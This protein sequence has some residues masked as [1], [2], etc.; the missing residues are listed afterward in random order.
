MVFTNDDPNL[1]QEG[2]RQAARSACEKAVMNYWRAMDGTISD[3]KV[4]DAVGNALFGTTEDVHSQLRDRFDPQDRLMLW[5]DFNLNDSKTIQGS[6]RKF[7][8]VGA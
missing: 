3:Q 8:E 1:T 4:Q 5:F 6:M 2:R 7:M